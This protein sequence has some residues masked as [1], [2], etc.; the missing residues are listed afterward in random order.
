MNFGRNSNMWQSLK[1]MSARKIFTNL[2]KY[3]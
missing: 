3:P 2:E 1:I